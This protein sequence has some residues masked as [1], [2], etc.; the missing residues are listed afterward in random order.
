MTS[1]PASKTSAVDLEQPLLLCTFCGADQHHVQQLIGG[2]DGIF[3]CDGCVLL[4]VDLIEEGAEN[5]GQPAFRHCLVHA[6]EP[7][8]ITGPRPDRRSSQKRRAP[9][10]IRAK[11]QSHFEFRD[12][13]RAGWPPQNSASVSRLRR[14]DLSAVQFSGVSAPHGHGPIPNPLIRPSKP[15]PLDL[16]LP[17]RRR[18]P[19]AREV[20]VGGSL[21]FPRLYLLG[22]YN[23]SH[24]D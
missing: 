8:T 1:K 4:C 13:V 3:I 19:H 14:R 6:D 21:S 10:K 16:L 9:T 12:P 23:G 15:A 20:R 7:R 18:V 24:H 17:A 5:R 11:R 2:P 22:A